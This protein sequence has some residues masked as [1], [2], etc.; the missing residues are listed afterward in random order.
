[1]LRQHAPAAFRPPPPPPNDLREA[2]GKIRILNARVGS[3]E[4]Q[5]YLAQ[6]RKPASAALPATASSSTL[7][8]R[9]KE[10]KQRED[11]VEARTGRIRKEQ[12]ELDRT[13][14][15]LEGRRRNAEEEMKRVEEEMKG[16]LDAKVERMRGEMKDRVEQ[17]RDEMKNEVERMEEEASKRA[18]IAEEEAEASKRA[19]IVEE[20][21]A[22]V[23]VVMQHTDEFVH[24]LNDVAAQVLVLMRYDGDART[25]TLAPGNS[26]GNS[27]V[28]V[29][30]M[31]SP[32]TPPMVFPNAT[33]RA[34]V[35]ET[36]SATPTT[37][38][39]TKPTNLGRMDSVCSSISTGSRFPDARIMPKLDL[40][41]A[42]NT[43]KSASAL[44]RAIL[45]VLLKEKTPVNLV[46]AIRPFIVE[47][48]RFNP[49]IVT[50]AALVLQRVAIK[51]SEARLEILGDDEMLDRLIS[52]LE[53]SILQTTTPTMRGAREMHDADPSMDVAILL[54]FQSLTAE[55]LMNG[56]V[57]ADA[58]APL[59]R[60]VMG[61]ALAKRM[62]LEPANSSEEAVEECACDLFISLLRAGNGAVPVDW[63]ASPTTWKLVPCPFRPGD[64]KGVARCRSI[65]NMHGESGVRFLLEHKIAQYLIDVMYTANMAG[66]PD[67]QA[68]SLLRAVWPTF[69]EKGSVVIEDEESLR[70]ITSLMTI[71]EGKYGQVVQ[72]TSAEERLVASSQAEILLTSMKYLQ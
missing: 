64:A 14:K 45:G 41:E 29:R 26:P 57:K 60:L 31:S 24:L 17:M 32:T 13:E 52:R 12:E 36:T 51:Y 48:T 20:E 54:L 5:L 37:P 1:M 70:L 39:A 72:G 22:P 3:L 50:S 27:P 7:S 25:Q 65:V 44:N 10:L 47:C 55:T 15:Q 58:L 61:G 40:D 19:R 2:E 66:L 6:Q 16:E 53:N 42:S 18:R 71:Y 46:R 30:A 21:G 4:E 67:Y 69:F 33:T 59:K 8:L 62:A 9:E 56:S 34:L 63:P 23:V 68:F 28:S 35:A 49:T 11:A 43:P 38:I